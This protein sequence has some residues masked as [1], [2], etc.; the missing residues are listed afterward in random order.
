MGYRPS[1]VTFNADGHFAALNRNDLTRKP[2]SADLNFGGGIIHDNQGAFSAEDVHI[3]WPVLSDKRA[4][5]DGD[6]RAAS[7]LLEG[8]NLLD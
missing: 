6:A 4:I 7:S 5:N 1:E 3:K 2:V 8:F